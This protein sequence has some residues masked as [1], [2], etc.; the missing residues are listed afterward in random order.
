MV[1][2]SRFI[3]QALFTLAISVLAAAGASAQ[4]TRT[5]RPFTGVKANTGTVSISKA[6]GHL[7][8]TLSNDFTVPDTPD[9]HWQV[10]DSKGTVY[11]LAR[12]DIKPGAMS[13]GATQSSATKGAENVVINRS[14]TLPNYIRDV[15]KV[16]I[17]CAFAETLLGE[18]AFDR[19]VT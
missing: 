4:M 19:P 11:L 17:W 2:V 3:S 15:A 16:Q 10:V 5:S 8:L 7:V 9:P 12:L 13:Q 1:R 14:V 6:N 18:A